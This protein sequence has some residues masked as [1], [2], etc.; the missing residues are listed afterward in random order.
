MASPAVATR[1]FTILLVEDDEDHAEL[2]FRCLREQLPHAQ[3]NHVRDGQAALD[4]L[5]RRGDY[6]DPARSPLP[7][8]ILLDLRLP[9]VDGLSVLEEVK[10]SPELRRVPAVV[11]TT[12]DAPKDL[13]RAYASHVNSYLVKPMDFEQFSRQVQDLGLYWVGW[14]RHP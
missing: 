2:V 8:L 1:G 14:N 3:V 7:E 11:L 6:E 4:Y 10:R 13:Q 9:L 12:S 5:L